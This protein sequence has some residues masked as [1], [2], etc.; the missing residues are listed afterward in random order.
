MI[1]HTHGE[2]LHGRLSAYRSSHSREN[3]SRTV[4]TLRGKARRYVADVKAEVNRSIE[5]E[6]LKKMKTE[7]EGAARDVEQAVAVVK[8][9]C[10]AVAARG[11]DALREFSAAFDRVT[12]EHL[13][14]P[15]DVLARCADEL[16][17][18]LRA[19]FVESIRQPIFFV[20]VMLCGVLQFFTTRGTGHTRELSSRPARA[21]DCVSVIPESVSVAVTSALSERP[22]GHSQLRLGVRESGVALP[23]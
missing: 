3:A 9:I 2:P 6:E 18:D 8:P 13:R 22:D 10:D 17:A 23:V 16:D 12:P 5:L 4:G 11:S 14:V 1:A 20:L 7:F 15:A 19:A 21:G